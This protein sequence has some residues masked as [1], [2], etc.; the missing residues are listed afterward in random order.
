MS[1]VYFIQADSF[2]SSQVICVVLGFIVMVL[3][4]LVEH[5]GQGQVGGDQGQAGGW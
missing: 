2:L 1:I 4:Q 5:G 3:V